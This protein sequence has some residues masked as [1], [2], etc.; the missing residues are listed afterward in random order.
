MRL[1]PF[2]SLGHSANLDANLRCVRVPV[3]PK[4][5]IDIEGRLTPKGK[6]TEPE[7]PGGRD[8]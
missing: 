2:G 1:E 8:F 5:N 7:L 3:A 6:L 4:L